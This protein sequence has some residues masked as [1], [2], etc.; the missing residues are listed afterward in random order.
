MSKEKNISDL[1]LETIKSQINAN[2]KILALRKPYD[3][4]KLEKN[5]TQNTTDKPSG[6]WYGIGTAWIDW[7]ESEMP[8]WRGSYFYK[9]I[10]SGN[11]LKLTTV[12]AILDFTKK[13]QKISPN[14][15]LDSYNIQWDLVANKFDGIEISPYQWKLRL[16]NR[17]NWYYGWDVASGC[18]WNSDAI[19]SVEEIIPSS[20]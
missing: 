19:L 14:K 3:K 2:D 8:G 18:I 15:F 5:Y 17:T 16:D 13:Y 1:E 6:L 20:G 7:V 12:D 11:V 4:A 10:T 9:L